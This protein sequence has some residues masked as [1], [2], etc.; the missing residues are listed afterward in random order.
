MNELDV[1]RAEHALLEDAQE[2]IWE[3]L[4]EKAAEY[5][6]YINGVYDMTTQILKML[7]KNE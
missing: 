7:K 2:W 5:V 3:D 6:N 1:L 4:D